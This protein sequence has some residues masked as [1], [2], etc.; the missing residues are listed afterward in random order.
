MNNNNNQNNPNSGNIPAG[1][2]LQQ[3]EEY[4][5]PLIKYKPKVF[6]KVWEPD[7]GIKLKYIQ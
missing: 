7:F 1:N 6:A 2:G 4:V 3:A 5:H